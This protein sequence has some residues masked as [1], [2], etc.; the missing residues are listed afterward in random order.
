MTKVEHLF[1]LQT[2][3][4]GGRNDS[5]VIRS[6]NLQTEISIPQVMNGPGIGTNPD[7]LLLSAAAGCYLITLAAMLER[8]SIKARL[9]LESIGIVE[10]ENQIITYKTITHH[11]EIILVEESDSQRRIAQRLAIKAEESCMI[12]RALKGNVEVR[13]ECTI[14][15]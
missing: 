15:A 5:G 6:G 1:S 14:R 12:S 4:N 10:E 11:I 8:S 13:V 2:E 3:W 9:S 7:E